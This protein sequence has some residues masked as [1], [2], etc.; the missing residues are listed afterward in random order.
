MKVWNVTLSTVDDD[1]TESDYC[2]LAKTSDG[3][4]KEAKRL[5]HIASHD[6]LNELVEAGTMS[7]A[8]MDEELK[9]V[10]FYASRVTMISEVDFGL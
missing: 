3:A 2:G 8:D 5:A 4:V 1:L 7:V 9:R 6:A 10:A